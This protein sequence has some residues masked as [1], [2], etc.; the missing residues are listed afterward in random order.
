MSLV[1]CISA[2]FRR[3]GGLSA[4]FSRRGG[5][6]AY[7]A[8]CGGIEATFC[9]RRTDFGCTAARTGGMSV[10]FGMVCTTGI[11]EYI[12]WGRDGIIFNVYG[13]KIYLTRK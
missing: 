10:S 7:A 11:G 1:S 5:L 3:I 4:S 9:Y 2:V 6:T 13:D 8:K 12:L